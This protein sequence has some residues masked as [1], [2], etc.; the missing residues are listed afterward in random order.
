MD[1]SCLVV[2]PILVKTRIRRIN[3]PLELIHQFEEAIER[4]T[5]WQVVSGL[6]ALPLLK[7]TARLLYLLHRLLDPLFCLLGGNVRQRRSYL[8]IGYLAPH[9]LIYKSFPYF[10]IP[11]GLRIVWMYDAWEA[12]LPSILAAVKRDR[13]NLLFVSSKQAAARLDGARSRKFRAHWVPEAVTVS[14]H[15][16]NP[17]R[18]RRI[19]VLQL[20]RRW[21]QYHDS[22]VEGCREVGITYLYE[23]TPGELVFPSRSEFIAGL[24]NTRIS[25]CVPA[26]ITHPTRAGEICTMTWRYF[27]SMA[28][29]CL[30]LGRAPEE[31]RDL[32]DYDPLIEI[33]LERPLEQL[34]ELLA[35]LSDYRELIERNFE[36]VKAWHQWPNRIDLMRQRIGEFVEENEL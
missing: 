10:S 9:Y 14:V 27:Q 28:S 24:A 35:H 17:M 4:H 7:V 15:E 16:Q 5:S 26:A 18:E 36:T 19:D 22:I 32:F 33:D 23:N 1:S 20:G 29:K 3:Q 21:N 34:Q 13:I 25:I 30:I 6:P 2:A 8:A 11:S 12:E 31:M